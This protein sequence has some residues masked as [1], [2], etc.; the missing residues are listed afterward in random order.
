[1]KWF[2]PKSV[3]ALTTFLIN[4]KLCTDSWF[5]DKKTFE[6]FPQVTYTPHQSHPQFYCFDRVS[7]HPVVPSRHLGE[8]EKKFIDIRAGICIWKKKF[9]N[10]N[11]SLHSL[12]CFSTFQLKSRVGETSE[13]IVWNASGVVDEEKTWKIYFQANKRPAIEN[14]QVAPL[15]AS[16]RPNETRHS[17]RRPLR[18][19]TASAFDRMSSDQPRG[20]RLGS[21]S[22]TTW[23]T[24]TRRD[25][26]AH[27]VRFDR[28][29]SQPRSRR[30]WGPSTR[31]R[32]RTP[33]Q[34]KMSDWLMARSVDTKL[35]N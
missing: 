23:T 13:T 9:Y 6:H 12:L 35:S 2:W 26:R 1:M 7:H 27:L 3:E 33:T 34:S 8:T 19:A 5:T 17:R 30:R 31:N 14:Q 18:A 20:L 22:T 21:M 32:G 29:S 25:R 28:V 10:W 4:L 15:L 11:N 16:S 24:T